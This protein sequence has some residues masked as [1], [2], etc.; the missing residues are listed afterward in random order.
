VVWW[1]WQWGSP[2]GPPCL[3]TNAAAVVPAL[4][5][6]AHLRILP[7]AKLGQWQRTS[8]GLVGR[9]RENNPL[10]TETAGTT[11]S[12]GLKGAPTCPSLRNGPWLSSH[13]SMQWQSIADMLF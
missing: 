13:P 6:T 8:Y 3:P 10:Q 1:Q 12:A 7:C 4:P 11:S 2:K 9:Q 5:Q